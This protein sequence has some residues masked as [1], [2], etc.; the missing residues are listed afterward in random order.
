MDSVSIL[1]PI[2]RPNMVWLQEQLNSIAAQTFR[3]FTCVVSHDGPIPDSISGQVYAVLPD[4]RFKLVLNAKHLGTYRHV[5]YLISEF[6]MMSKFFALC[7]QD[8]VWL[9]KKLESQLSRF[10]NLGVSAV[11]SNA[12]I[13][14]DALHSIRGRATFDWFGISQK[15][16]PFGSVRNQLTGASGLFRSDRLKKVTPFPDNAG[17]AVHDHWLYIAAIATGGVH[18]DYEPQWFYRQHNGNQI[19]AS[20]SSGRL[21]RLYKGVQKTR[22]ILRN[23]C[24]LKDDPVIRQGRLFLEAANERWLSDVLKNDVLNRELSGIDRIRLL[25][26]ATLVGSS[27][28]SLRVAISQQK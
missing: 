21:S 25:R 19:G 28:E 14:N 17:E 6:G 12:L 15:Y 23:R 24:L 3:G 9:P 16:E 27:L 20:A 8:D 13:V 5:D 22:N 1:L 4:S 7:D 11:S 26:S 2:Y 18:F 10:S